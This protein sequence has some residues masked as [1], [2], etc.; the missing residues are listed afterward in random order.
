MSICQNEPM[1]D[2]VSTLKGILLARFP[3]INNVIEGWP[4]PK[5]FQVENNLP[6]V[7]ILDIHEKGAPATSRLAVHA[8]VVNTDGTA[9]IVTEQMRLHTLMQI[10]VFASTKA[11]RDSLGWQ[12]KQYLITNYHIA[13]IDYT[14]A[15]PAPT[16]EYAMMYYRSDHKDMRGSANFY[17][18][19]LTFEVQTRVL[20]STSAVQVKGT[21]TA[22]IIA[23]TTGT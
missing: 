15:T 5:W 7:A 22:T 1:S 13:L 20:D 23:S 6:I 9:A 10:S 19:D 14:L 8:T 21:P 16:G 3:S 17:Q 11:V 2:F 18:R 12:I 4:D